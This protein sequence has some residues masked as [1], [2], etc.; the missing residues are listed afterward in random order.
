M[1]TRSGTVLT[2][3]S[4]ALVGACERLG[5]DTEALLRA[6]GISRRTL[7]DPDARLEASKVSALWTK[8][9]EMSGDPVLSLH[10]AEACPLGAYKVIDFMA[11]NAATVGEAFRYSARYFRLINTAVALPI[12]ESGDPVTFDVVDETGPTGVSRPYAEYCLAAFVL[13]IRATTG[14]SF[15]L[16]RITFVHRE[17]PDI[18][19]HERIFGCPVQFEAEHNRLYVARQ[20]WDT[21]AT[22]SPQPG[23]LQLL[24]EHADL[25]LQKLPRGP[26]L[27]ERTRHAIGEKLRG[28]D[29]SLESVARELGTSGR[30]LQRHLGEHA[31]HA[32][33]AD[34]LDG[35]DVRGDELSVPLE[36]AP[37]RRCERLE[38]RGGQRDHGPSAPRELE[39]VAGEALELV[40][41]EVD[42]LVVG[43]FEQRAHAA[44]LGRIRDGARAQRGEARA[45]GHDDVGVIDRPAGSIDG[46]ERHDLVG[47]LAAEFRERPPV[48]SRRETRVRHT[49]HAI[50][51]ETTR[52][53][54][55]FAA[56]LERREVHD[57]VEAI[58]VLLLEYAPDPVVLQHPVD[59]CKVAGVLTDDPR[60]QVVDG[61]GG[62]SGRRDF[63]N[64]DAAIGR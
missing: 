15:P 56:F 59:R 48:S 57:A 18:T 21:R 45:D 38:R 24:V 13:R 28:G 16:R 39:H 17:P 1:W 64:R 29:S 46:M 63:C 11:F 10:A 2:V 5:V 35:G 12:D 37:C 19:E 54:E 20:V 42:D 8:A 3:S 51:H 40:D 55:I 27:V 4:R 61:V 33:A 60:P 22:T 6:V 50:E 32:A 14:V 52:T 58:A 7:D 25:L 9:Y 47:E 43:A 31:A 30:S 53:L 34:A 26:D 49:L 41:A 44:A 62:R 23:V 36:R